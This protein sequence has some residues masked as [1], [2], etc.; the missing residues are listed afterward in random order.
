MRKVT[1]VQVPQI[2]MDRK[3]LGKLYVSNYNKLN[4]RDKFLEGHKLLYSAHLK[5]TQEEMDNLNYI[6]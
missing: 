2:L 1:S 4:E 6:Y 5:L 3:R